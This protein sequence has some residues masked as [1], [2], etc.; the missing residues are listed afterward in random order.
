V[1]PASFCDLFGVFLKNVGVSDKP[2]EIRF[3]DFCAGLGGFHRGLS[4]A[5]KSAA[6]LLGQSISFRCVA[7]SELEND[8]RECYVANFP[9][10][11]ETY[12]KLHYESSHYEKIESKVIQDPS[13]LSALPEFDEGGRLVKIHG[14]MTWFL[15]ETESGLRKS[16]SGKTLLPEHDMLCAGFPCQPF[17]KS[18][19]Q[20][21]FDDTRGTVFHTIA[22]ILKEMSP[23]FLLLEN[24]GNFARHDGGNT[25]ARVRRILEVDLGYDIVATEHV[26]TGSSVGLISPHHFGYPHHRERFFIVGQRKRPIR[27]D[28]KFIRELLKEPL[29]KRQTFPTVRANGLKSPETG[30]ALDVKAKNGL[31][32]IISGSKLPSE[33]ESLISSQISPDRVRCINHWAELLNKLDEL[34]I[35]GATPLWRDT[36]PSFPIWGYELDP[37]HWYPIH[38]NPAKCASNFENLNELR[39]GLIKDVTKRIR[40]SS[41]LR[42]DISK[43]APRG[44]RAWLSKPL[45][46]QRTAEWIEFWPGYAGKRDEWP[47][48]KQRFIEQNRDWAIKLWSSVEPEW[49]RAWLDT[50]YDVIR[51][52]SYQKLEW[53]CKG[54]DLQIWNHI[55]QF[56]PSGLRV[57]R[58]A[59]V[60]ALVAM[61]TTQIP[62][63]PRMNKDESLSGGVQGAL[64][65]HLIQ[66]EA[67]QL[68]GFPSNWTLPINRERAFTCFGNAV[69]VGVVYQVVTNWLLGP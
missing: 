19:A 60:P 14:D 30:R 62:I 27:S 31:K 20:R 49:L 5:A 52:P 10:I 26:G 37:W 68:Q 42:T 18:G 23:A 32:A 51:V 4:E 48:W 55:L 57:K 36:M 54:D 6:I 15:D 34:D 47:R 65:R 8:L 3:V 53:N 29:S 67:L 41:S 11:N 35:Q 40:E 61:T 58:L 50:L 46:T 1:C 22:T 2:R 7:A 69:H 25:W 45:N 43:Y 38:E 59:H 56:R 21:G 33:N 44:D 12:G 17:S 13:F 24:V 28:S 64:G 9:E 63:V 39:I 16:K 66:S